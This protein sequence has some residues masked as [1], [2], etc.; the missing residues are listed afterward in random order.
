MRNKIILKEVQDITGFIH[1]KIKKLIKLGKLEFDGVNF[2]LNNVLQYLEEEKRI[3]HTYFTINEAMSYLGFCKSYNL[4][5]LQL[6]YS[7]ESS[8]LK[9]INTDVSVDGF[10]IF[11]EKESVVQFKKEILDGRG[12]TFL[13]ITDVMKRYEWSHQKVLKL[14]KNQLKVIGEDQHG[15]RICLKSAEL[16]SK[17]ERDFE[18]EIRDNYYSMGDTNELLGFKRISS[19]SAKRLAERGLLEVIQLD[20]KLDGSYYWYT[21]ESVISLKKK[22]E[23]EYVKCEYV[24][25]RTGLSYS[26]VKQL[27]SKDEKFVFNNIMYIKK[28]VAMNVVSIDKSYYSLAEL[29]TITGKELKTLEKELLKGEFHTIIKDIVEPNH[30]NGNWYF[31]TKE[32]DCY[33]EK[34]KA[35][36]ERF[37]SKS[38]FLQY[39]ELEEMPVL[40]PVKSINT[41]QYMRLLKAGV[42]ASLY[43]KDDARK[44][45]SD[46]K[47]KNEIFSSAN[48]KIDITLLFILEQMNFPLHLSETKKYIKQYAEQFFSTTNSSYNGQTRYARDLI[49]VVDYILEI[50]IKKE[51]HYCNDEEIRTILKMCE[52]N[53]HQK[54]LYNIL[55]YISQKR[56]CKYNLKNVISPHRK[57]GR[58]KRE[59]EVLDF[60]TF[61]DIYEFCHEI[62]LHIDRAISNK[63]Y[64]SLWLYVMVLITNSWRHR[65][66]LRIPSI[67]PELIGIRNIQW[68]KYNTLNVAQG[69]K[70][71]NIIH[72]LRLVTAKNG[73]PRDFTCNFDLIV[74]MVTAM[75]ICE[76]HR[77]KTNIP[78]LV[79]VTDGIEEAKEKNGKIKKSDD[80]GNDYLQKNFFL[81]SSKLRDVRF[82]SLIA[83]NSLMEHLFYSIKEKKGKGNSVFELMMKY[84]SHKSTIT[85]EYIRCDGNKTSLQL[86]D[87]GEFGFIFDRLVEILTENKTHSIKERTNEIKKFKMFFEPIEVE[88]LFSFLKERE[89]EKRSL[90]SELLTLK[91]HDALELARKMY[92][93]E[94]PAKQ[95][96]VQCLTYP[97]CHRKSNQFSCHSC[98]FAVHNVYALTAIFNEFEERVK[99]YAEAKKSGIRKREI[100][101]IVNIQDVI[102]EAIN[103]FGQEYVFSFYNGGETEFERKLGLLEGEV[104]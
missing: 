39:I 56:I 19:Q 98:V 28:E 7:E 78:I 21:K 85:Q 88:N 11:I 2:D 8:I 42:P 13:Y 87:R 35:L 60:E 57:S 103:Q 49:R 101:I 54:C 14:M 69:Q 100:K 4:S 1:Q 37:F 30:E 12:K 10:R 80:I 61:K 25:E 16:V 9:I 84:R 53:T 48:I 24:I 43:S 46:S 89:V 50:T 74:P 38:E 81:Y 94:M 71:I 27:F 77:R 20:T 33:L 51:L 6:V 64:A 62:D 3:R 15:I 58:N 68:F 99:I 31:N 95:N 90:S 67:T 102:L 26:R 82:S 55:N 83:N 5:K 18:R 73:M 44:Y 36:E 17:E 93:G 92:L 63:K 40:H 97:K 47:I 41:P 70:I 75:C 34:I 91:P 22:L 52:V 59:K 32:V 86:F 65:D 45:G 29:K 72:S 66:V 104:E 23:E 96:N 79:D 76:F